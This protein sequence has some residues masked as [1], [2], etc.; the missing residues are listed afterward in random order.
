MVRASSINRTSS[1][2]RAC[3]FLL[4]FVSVMVNLSDEHPGPMNRLSTI[5][6]KL[7]NSWKIREKPH[8]RENSVKSL[9]TKAYDYNWRCDWASRGRSWS[10]IVKE[11]RRDTITG[12]RLHDEVPEWGVDNLEGI[13]NLCGPRRPEGVDDIFVRAVLDTV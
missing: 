7:L 2:N 13:L 12:R 8:R 5:N 4:F 9:H 3:S 1:A 10:D 6:I 11:D